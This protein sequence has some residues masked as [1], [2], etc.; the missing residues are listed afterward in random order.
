VSTTFPTTAAPTAAG[1]PAPEGGTASPEV[2][3][4]VAPIIAIVGRP[5]VGKSALFNRLTRSKRALVEDLPG[6]TR[7]RNYGDL[8][9]RGR[10]IRVV[11]TGGLVEGG[12]DPFSPLIREGVEDAIAAARLVLFV[13]DAGEG[14][15]AADEEIAAGLRRVERPIL[16]V[17]NKADLGR[18]REGLLDLYAL[19]LGEPIA[20]SAYHGQGVGDLLDRILDEVPAERR[21]ARV[22][23]IRIAVV[24]RPNVG[25]SSL[26]NAILGEQRSIVSD[27]PG[28]TRDPID[29]AFEFEGHPLLLVDTAGIRRRGRIERGVERHSVQRAE[30]AIDRADIAVLVIDQAEAAAAQDAHIAGYVAKQAKG[31]VLVVNKWDLTP[32]PEERPRFARRLDYRYRFAPWAPLLFTSALTGEGVRDVVETAIHIA[33]VRRRRVQTSELN[34]V[35]QRAL[36]EHGPPTV[37]HRR[38]KVMYV[39]QA[40]VAPP[41]FVCFVNDP[42]LVHFSYERYLENRLRAAFDFEGTAIRLLFRRRSEDRHEGRK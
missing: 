8:E 27:V 1:P 17:A 18:A 34:R 15:T 32:D 4:S 35:V 24:G 12:E 9:W 11:D 13:V 14:L 2:E 28:T 41:T 29:T 16:L 20:V 42:S 39:T 6:T 22:D 30:R 10:H 26:I 3:P 5:N 25:K 33:E 37:R 36:Y 38:L 23:R 21:P 31:L 19:G 7:D 40:E